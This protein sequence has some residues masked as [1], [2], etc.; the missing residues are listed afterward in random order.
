MANS[1]KTGKIELNVEGMS[2]D[3]CEAN[4]RIALAE[5]EGV[6]KVVPHTNRCTIYGALIE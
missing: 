4:V 5:V 2:C 6:K 1:E 3:G